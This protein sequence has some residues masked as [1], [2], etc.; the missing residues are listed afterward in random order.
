MHGLLHQ[1]MKTHFDSSA[2]QGNIKLQYQHQGTPNDVRMFP[3]ATSTG[4][5][6]T[7]SESIPIAPI[8]RT[9]SEIDFEEGLALAEYREYVMYTRI[10]RG[11]KDLPRQDN[12]L[13]NILTTPHLQLVK[14]DNSNLYILQD[15]QFLRPVDHPMFQGLLP[16]D[17]LDYIYSC[18]E[19][20]EPLPSEEGI[21][22]LE[23]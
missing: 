11:K 5:R 13:L 14:D 6:R 20:H 9:Q 2:S 15:H 18:N 17:V 10:H 8:E 22:E 23:M 19:V 3:Q 1:A 16:P 4:I 21:F 12:S 7:C